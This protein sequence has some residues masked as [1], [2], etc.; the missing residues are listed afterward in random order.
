MQELTQAQQE[1]FKDSKIRNR[2]GELI[3]VYHGSKNRG[4]DAFEYSPE[5]QTGQDFGEAYYFTTDYQSAKSYAYDEHKDSRM[6]E[7]NN[8]K[9]QLIDN[10]QG[11]GSL[12]DAINRITVDGKTANEITAEADY[13]R[14]GG[15]IHAVYLDLRNPLIVDAHGQTFYNAY[16]AYFEEAKENG[17]DG[18]VV[19][20]ASDSARGQAR[21]TD[22]FIAFH[23]SQIKSVTNLYPTDSKE[24]KDN[25]K[26]YLQRYGQKLSFDERIRLANN[27]VKNDINKVV[28]QQ[29][30]RKE[31]N[32]GRE[33]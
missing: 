19:L 28:H 22:V 29:E 15:E 18:I 1:Y 7:W 5:R 23:P 10:Y 20:N 32:N 13:N 6:I 21:P 31:M 33:R 25:S 26:D 8:K 24:F 14:T 12:T 2:N 11:Q 17:Y 3:T 4:F 9:E 27:V 30:Q 16:P